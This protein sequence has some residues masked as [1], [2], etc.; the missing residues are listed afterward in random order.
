MNSDKF[1]PKH[2]TYKVIGACTEVQKTL[3]YGFAEVIYKDAM[4]VEFAK[5]TF[6]LLEK[7]N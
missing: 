6:L 3:G 4:E 1:P 5:T 7:S 2:E